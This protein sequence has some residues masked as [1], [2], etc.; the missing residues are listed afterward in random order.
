MRSF[1]F[2]HTAECNR[3]ARIGNDLVLFR[4]FCIASIA[5][6]M[7]YDYSITFAADSQPH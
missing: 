3:V 6:V 4:S 1:L 7:I 2:A 5:C